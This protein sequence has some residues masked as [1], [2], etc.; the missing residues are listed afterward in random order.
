MRFILTREMTLVLVIRTDAL[1]C[2]RT[3]LSLS[4]LFQR[5]YAGCVRVSRSRL[6]YSSTLRGLFG[7][8]RS[9]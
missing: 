1:T 3:P 7:R 8:F 4:V 5:Q 6:I 9:L 2:S